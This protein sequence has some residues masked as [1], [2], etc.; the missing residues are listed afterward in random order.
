MKKIVAFGDSITYPAKDGV[1][2]HTIGNLVALSGADFDITLIVCLRDNVT[3]PSM[4]FRIIYVPPEKYYNNVIIGS[5]LDSLEPDILQTYSS[6][7][8]RLVVFDYASGKRIPT[9]VEHHDVDTEHMAVYRKRGIDKWQREALQRASLSRTLSSADAKKLKR[10]MPRFADKIHNVP[11]I[12]THEPTVETGTSTTNSSGILFVG[13]CSY[14]PNRAAAQFIIDNIAPHMSEVPFYIAGRSSESLRI[15]SENVHALG[16]VDKISDVAQDCRIGIAP[17]SDGSGLKLKILTYLSH[18]L[19]VVGT[20]V[21]FAGFE[22][23]RYLYKTTID[24]FLTA[25]LSVYD[26]YDGTDKVTIAQHYDTMYAT[27]RSAEYLQNLYRSVKFSE[28]LTP[29]NTM[30]VPLDEEYIPLLNEK[31]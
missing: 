29:E 30:P 5:L 23:R 1:S 21:A 12:L 15:H 11:S 27:D 2:A 20:E 17:L 16:F 18:G 26:N 25:L 7:Y 6:Y 31:R 28:T 22:D 3:L 9:I 24:N 4:P 10:L 8:A 19:P 13:N 14:P